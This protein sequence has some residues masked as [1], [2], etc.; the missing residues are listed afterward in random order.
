MIKKLLKFIISLVAFSWLAKKLSL[1]HCNKGKQMEPLMTKLRRRMEYRKWGKRSNEKMWED[2]IYANIFASP[3]QLQ[4]LYLQYF[5]VMYLTLVIVVTHDIITLFLVV[6]SNRSNVVL[7]S[8]FNSRS[9]LNF[10]WVESLK[11]IR[12][13]Y[14]WLLSIAKTFL[15]YL[16]CYVAPP[17]SKDLL[18]ISCS[19]AWK[20][21]RNKV[22]TDY[23][24]LPLHLL[25]IPFGQ[26]KGCAGA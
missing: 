9:V 11:A 19:T 12:M 1:H 7:N 16:W 15:L 2:L 3:T 20:M 25:V 17:Y 23:D 21:S 8:R 22:V 13:W 5:S 18:T 6:G 4:F 14:V 10:F 24:L 26:G